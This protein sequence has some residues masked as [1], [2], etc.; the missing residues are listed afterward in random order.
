MANFDKM[1]NGN[2]KGDV[3]LLP[4]AMRALRDTAKRDTGAYVD[5]INTAL[6]IY[7]ALSAAAVA[8]GDPQAVAL[9]ILEALDRVG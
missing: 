3:I 7:D 6:V 1:A 8:G 2:F 9:R 5:V 4:E